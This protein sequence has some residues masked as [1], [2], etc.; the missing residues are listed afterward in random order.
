MKI[1]VIIPSFNSEMTIIDSISSVVGQSISE[2]IEILIINDGS[3]DNSNKIVSEYISK[4]TGKH[5]INLINKHNGGVSSARNLGIIHAS[6]EWIAFLDAD[7]IWLPEKLEEQI[8]IINANKKIEFIGTNRNNDNHPFFKKSKRK[9]YKLNTRHILLKWHPHTSTVL[10]QKKIL[11]NAGL[12]DEIRSH[13]EDGDLW[14]RIVDF[15]DLYVLNKNLVFTGHGKRTFGES[16]LSANM[17]KMYEGEILAL[18][19]ARKRKQLNFLEFIFFYLWL[20]IKY[21]R[22]MIIVRFLS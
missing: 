21:F 17:P 3:T 10:V 20:S 11:F 22:R 13:A 1:S 15:C 8:N 9:L 18:S 7:D 14:L 5:Q 12:Y 2:R 4:Y 16:G 19:S 6:G